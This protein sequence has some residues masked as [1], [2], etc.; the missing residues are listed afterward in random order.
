MAIG[1]YMTVKELA[2]SAGV[3][4]STVR[5]WVRRSRVPCRRDPGGRLRIYTADAEALANLSAEVAV[6][7]RVWERIPQA[8]RKAVMDMARAFEAEARTAMLGSEK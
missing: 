5:R 2:A 7:A 4:I 3:S 1:D 8:E 6:L